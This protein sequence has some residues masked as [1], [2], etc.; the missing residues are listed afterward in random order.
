MPLPLYYLRV[1]DGGGLLPDNNR[2]EQYAGLE[3]VYAAARE[4][5]QDVLRVAAFSG[6][7]G[8]T[9]REIEVSDA[10]GRTV[11]TIGCGS[12]GSGWKPTPEDLRWAPLR[13]ASSWRRSEGD[14]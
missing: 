11:L 4:R 13:S 14:R 12:I 9:R 3:Q 1:R 5:F 6:K 10:S 7:A 8:S 2:G